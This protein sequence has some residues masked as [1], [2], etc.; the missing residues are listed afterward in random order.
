MSTKKNFKRLALAVTSALT[1]SFLSVLPAEANHPWA[2]DDIYINQSSADLGPTSSTTVEIYVDDA[3]NTGDK[4]RFTLSQDA[5]TAKA[6]VSWKVLDNYDGGSCWNFSANSGSYTTAL[7]ITALSSG[8]NM[9]FTLQLKTSAAVVGASYKLNVDTKPNAGAYSGTTAELFDIDIVLSADETGLLDAPLRVV[10]GQSNVKTTTQTSPASISATS[11]VAEGT[12]VFKLEAIGDTMYKA[13]YTGA[14]RYVRVS[15]T[16][17]STVAAKTGNFVVDGTVNSATR[18]YIPLNGVID[19]EQIWFNAGT[20]GTLVVEVVDRSAL[21][22]TS[23]FMPA[24]Y[25]PSFVETVLQTITLTIGAAPALSAQQSTSYINALHSATTGIA[26][27]KPLYTAYNFA[28]C[29]GAGAGVVACDHTVLAPLTANGTTARAVIQVNLKDAAGLPLET[30]AL[31]SVGASITGAGTLSISLVGDGTTTPSVGRSLS[32]TAAPASTFYINVFS[33]GNGGKS[34]VSILVGGGVWATKTI[35]FYSST[36]TN[37]KATQGRF[38]LAA[39]E[40]AGCITSVSVCDGSTVAKTVATSIVASDANGNPV[41]FVKYT[42][43]TSD[44]TILTAG[45]TTAGYGDFAADFLGASWFQVPAVPN[46]LAGKTATMTYTSGTLTQSLTFAIGGAAASASLSVAAGA[47]I[48]EA[49][50]F[51]INVKD[52]AGNKA[53]DNDHSLA[54]S[55]NLQT[56]IASPALMVVDGK[57]TVPFFNPVVPGTV[58]LT[59]LIDSALP[60]SG[61]WSVASS[62]ADAATDAAMEAIDAANAATDAA[63]LAAEAADAATVAAEEAREAADAATAA[64]EELATQVA[65]LMAALKAQITT[66]ANTVAKIAKKVKA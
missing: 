12:D 63:Q 17:G 6:A 28:D 40:T 43:A 48:G 44:A 57:G 9:Y 39:G 23:P 20:V 60:I 65:T 52:A 1:L 38:V 34:T 49:G 64:V 66:L 22:D 7:E 47:N 46:A 33:D 29:D 16:S 41:P 8:C 19:G 37:I 32:A 26:T 14:Y 50:V 18:V 54:I 53:Y 56:T 3:V 25:V 45:N 27:S 5:G 59:G 31:P 21:Y 11:V 36:V 51:T 24:P 61:T 2:N 4:A 62:S 30:K 15:G 13:P 55:T 10:S 42:E 58:T 35:T